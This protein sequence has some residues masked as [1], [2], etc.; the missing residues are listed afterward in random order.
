MSRTKAA[1]FGLLI[2]IIGFGCLGGYKLYQRRYMSSDLKRTLL[3]AMDP[4]A[5]ESDIL[6]YI[7]DA[8]LQ[9]L[10]RKDAEVLQKL[11]TCVQLGRDSSEVNSRLTKEY[12]EALGSM[13]PR[14]SPFDKLVALRSEYWAAH[15]PVP[16]D[17]LTRMDQA[18]A[19]EKARQ[20]RQK[21][22]WEAEEKRAK[23][24]QATAQKLYKEVRA[25]LGLPPLQVA[26]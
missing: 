17:L 6:V 12:F 11:Q 8:R 7:R 26:K 18:M 19:G 16:K 4:T 2:A 25:E 20:K 10:T 23:E 5:S 9:V 13:V 24:E 3:V 15:L 21:E 22:T 1:I 14:N